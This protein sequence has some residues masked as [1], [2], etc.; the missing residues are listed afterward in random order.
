VYRQIGKEIERRQAEAGPERARQ[1]PGVVQR[2]S[3]DLLAAL[4]APGAF[5]ANPPLCE[6]HVRGRWRADRGALR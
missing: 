6:G 3:A 1:T 5:D 2:Q 4:L